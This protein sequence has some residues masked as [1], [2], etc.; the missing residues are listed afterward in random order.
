VPSST[1][2]PSEPPIPGCGEVVAT[3]AAQGAWTRP[4]AVFSGDGLG[5]YDVRGDSVTP[6]EPGGGAAGYR[7]RFRTAAQVTYLHNRE[8]FDEAHTFGQESL[9][10]LDLETNEARELVRLPNHVLAFEWNSDGTVLAYLV[11]AET[12][13][14]G[15]PSPLCL[16]D[17]RSG[18]ITQIKA[19]SYTIGRGGNQW[20]ERSI[21]WSPSGTHLL[22]LDTVQSPTMYVVDLAGRNLIRPREGTFARWRSDD[23]IVYL[24]D[25]NHI[26]EGGTWRAVSIDSGRARDYPL[27]GGAFRAAFSPNGRFVVYD[28]GARV[29]SVYLFDLETRTTRLLARGYVQPI[30]L[31]PRR[32]AAAAAG[33]CPRTYWCVMPWVATE[34]TI[35]I[36]P[37]TGGRNRL[38]LPTTLQSGVLNGPIDIL[39]PPL[40]P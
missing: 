12:Q 40:G 26:D 18:G 23:E 29:P 1:E 33:R 7:P 16:F 11:A 6:L 36:D 27:P 8:P 34:G 20:D 35:G 28:D 22:V 13:R 3:T 24:M 4:L 21:A 9:Y 37:I 5:L 14:R 19:L 30:W 15:L 38:A 10:E 25:S 32:I 2:G 17:T 39:R 31:G